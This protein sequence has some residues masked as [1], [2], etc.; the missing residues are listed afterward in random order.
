VHL[1]FEVRVEL[2]LTNGEELWAQVTR[3]EAERLELVEGARVRVRP[4]HA[5][6]F[7]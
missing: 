7:G 4:R 3:E 5:K 6:V 2:R 1:G